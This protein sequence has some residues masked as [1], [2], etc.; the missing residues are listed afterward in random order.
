MEVSAS[1]WLVIILAIAA[2]NLPFFNERLLTVVPLFGWLVKPFWMRLLELAVLY[3]L[4]GL[5][6]NLLESNAGNRFPQ[7]WEFYA[8]TSCL[9]I[10]LAF[11]G[12]VYRYL[13]KQ[14]G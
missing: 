1:A 10:V 13:R 14:H 8:I 2:A 3:F 11:P 7:T 5:V 4:L 9:F 12:F 6:A